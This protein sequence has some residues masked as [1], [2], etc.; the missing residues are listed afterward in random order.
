MSDIKIDK[1][2]LIYRENHKQI[3]FL[4]KQ[5][6]YLPLT[7][8]KEIIGKQIKDVKTKNGKVTYIFIKLENRTIDLMEKIYQQNKCLEIMK[9]DIVSFD[10]ST[11]FYFR[12]LTKSTHIIAIKQLDNNTYKKEVFTLNGLKLSSVEDK[13]ESNNLV[14]RKIKNKYFLEIEN[15]EIVYSE[16]TINLRS[17][18][19]GKILKK[20][21][22]SFIPNPNIGVIDLETYTDSETQKARVYSAGLYSI[23]NTEPITFYIDKYT[24]D[25]IKY[26][27]IYLMKCLKQSINK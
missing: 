9:K 15:N 27:M 7:T 6:N 12:D 20:E 5:I 22:K 18:K 26:C 13:I 21:K 11:K 2:T 1:N 4:D 24:M 17:I 3:Q 16:K 10:E 23:V 14:T 25:G 19:S 8:D